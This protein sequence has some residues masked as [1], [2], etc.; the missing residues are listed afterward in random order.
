M[1][2]ENHYFDFSETDELIESFRTTGTTSAL[3]KLQGEEIQRALKLTNPVATIQML[4]GQN[5]LVIQA[6]AM[7]AERQ[8]NRLT[9]LLASNIVL[10]GY[11]AYLSS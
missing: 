11:I 7:R 10:V 8:L 4:L 1:T 2:E 9:L 5:I 6:N 3:L